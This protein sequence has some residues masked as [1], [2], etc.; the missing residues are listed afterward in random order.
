MAIRLTRPAPPHRSAYVSAI[1]AGQLFYKMF[2]C[3]LSLDPRWAHASGAPTWASQTRRGLIAAW[4]ASHRR[5]SISPLG[6]L[7]AAIVSRRG[8]R[9]ARVGFDMSQVSDIPP[10][11]AHRTQRYEFSVRY[12]PRTNSESVCAYWLTVAIFLKE[13]VS[14]MPVLVCA[15]QAYTLH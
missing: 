3:L 15:W 6:P 1:A 9:R 5:R 7:A 8:E 12:W 2:Y 11:S 10:V 14:I 13:H 4:H